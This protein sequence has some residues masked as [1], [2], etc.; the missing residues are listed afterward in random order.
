[1]SCTNKT[2]LRRR[3][4]VAAALAL[5]LSLGMT[6][7]ALATGGPNESA[8]ADA[9]AVRIA[10]AD[11]AADKA[12]KAASVNVGAT[13]ADERVDAKAEARTAD[14]PA[15]SEAKPAKSEAMPAKS[16]A[17]PAKSEAKPAKSEAKPAKSEAKPAKSEAKPAKS[18]S[19]I[20]YR[21]VYTNGAV[22]AGTFCGGNNVTRADVPTLNAVSLH[23]SCSDTFINGTAVK[24]D[25][26]GLT[27]QTWS[28]DKGNGKT[29][30]GTPAVA[31]PKPTVKPTKKPSGPGTAT[32]TVNA[33]CRT[34]VVT[35]SKDISNVV[36]FF[37]DGTSIKFD[38][39]SGKRWTRTFTKDVASARAKSATTTVTAVATGCGVLPTST[40]TPTATPTS[41]PPATC[42]DGSTMPPGG[43]KNCPRDHGGEKLTI[44]H[45]T[46]SATN[47]FVIITI[48]KAGVVNGH[49]GT[50]HQ[51]GRDIIPAF[52]YKGVSYPAQGDQ[53]LL[54][55]G[56][57]A[58]VPTSTATPTVPPT[59]ACPNMP[60]NQAPGTD[61]TPPTDVC[62]DMPG[63][64]ATGPCT[65][66]VVDACPDVP[67]TQPMGPCTGSGGGIVD[68]CPNMPGDQPAGTVCTTPIGGQP[69]AQP[70]SNPVPVGPPTGVPP[71]VVPNTANPPTVIGGTS[72]QPAQARAVPSTLPFT[73]TA[74]GHE[75]EHTQLGD[76]ELLADEGRSQ[77]RVLELRARALD[78]R[79][80][81]RVVVEG[82]RRDVDRLHRVPGHRPGPSTG[83]RWRQVGGEDQVG[84]RDHA[85]PRVA[86]G[87]AV[88]AQLLD[89]RSVAADPGLVLQPADCCLVQVLLR[90]H[91]PARQRQR[92]AEGV[93]V[94]L[95]EQDAQ[96]PGVHG[97]QDD[98]DRHRERRE[99][100]RVVA[101]QPG[102]L[103]GRRGAPHAISTPAASSSF[104]VRSPSPGCRSTARTPSQ[105]TTTGQPSWRPS[106]AVARTQ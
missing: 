81:H 12:D 44:C 85:H 46:G 48:S 43:A 97:Q 79:G 104:R 72:A 64:Q 7:T 58:V 105:G 18:G 31:S 28:I 54:A 77:R 96:P 3:R 24:S 53:S 1:M 5:P 101:P 99:L 52:T 41:T 57:A 42:P 32:V 92:A 13:K 33:D 4:I 93:G 17:M 21:F 87:S 29:C 37:K 100:R 45:A 25:L 34:V 51:G 11:K 61:C 78:A 88:R 75:E 15:K 84:H 59:D 60:G 91:E 66:P 26:G 76:R 62:P 69:P 63:N 98:V 20:T 82:Q 39:L 86:V 22:D 74:A 65:P 94:P 103:V 30:G 9:A 95:H 102:P 70:G 56:C 10:G 35:S 27:I 83:D 106:S 90:A 49:Y 67:G 80:Q 89:V 73:G 68:V 23:I 40:P 50:S 38:G 36:V 47:P 71:V 55:R 6:G 19:C 8:S 14:K 2:V 16:E